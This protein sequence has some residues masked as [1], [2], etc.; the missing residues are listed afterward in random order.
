[1]KKIET[2]HNG[3]ISIWKFIYCVMIILYHISLDKSFNEK[4][5]F[6]YGAIGV[7][8][9]FIVSGYL[10]AKKAIDF[11]NV[12]NENIGIETWR[13]ILKKVKIF[14]PYILMVYFTSLPIMAFI[15]KYSRYNVL[16]SIWEL[17]LMQSSGLYTTRVIPVAWYISSMILCSLI[18][19]PLILKYRNN[20]IYIFAPISIIFIWGFI[21]KRNG[22]FT[23]PWI[24]NTFTIVGNLRAFFELSL[25]V[26]VYDIAEKIKKINFTKISKLIISIIEFIGFISILLFVNIDKA[27]NKYDSIMLLIMALSI[28]LAFSEKTLLFSF[29]NNKVFYFLEKLSLPMYLN[30][31]WIIYLLR[32]II[33][34]TQTIH[35][36]FYNF[37]IIV[38]I[39]DIIVSLTNMAILKYLKKIFPKFKKIFVN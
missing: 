24:W 21:I 17:L 13:F 2:K 39:V 3:I 22:N 34:K 31:I 29:C 10:L 26:I 23:N 5:T 16:T 20:Y 9:F 27:N 18:L 4:Y 32:Y 8:F 25:G 36:S 12:K 33:K 11:G 37:S 1:M 35:L 6:K 28:T 15:E 14:Y 19:F 30:Q 38:I 7:E